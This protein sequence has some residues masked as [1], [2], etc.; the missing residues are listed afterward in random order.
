MQSHDPDVFA[1]GDVAYFFDPVIGHHHRVEHWDNAVKQ[2]RLAARNMLGKRLPYE[3]VS[4]FYSQIFDNSFNLLGE[5]EASYERIDRGSLQEKSFAAFY[6]S[7]DVPR[8][9]FSLGRPT[10]ETRLVETLIKHRV[11]L[12]VS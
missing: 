10:Q 3:E 1:A 5:I 7:E 4:Y 6:L 2:G 9:L 11:N 8:A 12:R